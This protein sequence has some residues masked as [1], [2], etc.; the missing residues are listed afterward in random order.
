MCRLLG[1]HCLYLVCPFPCPIYNIHAPT[2]REDYLNAVIAA[3]RSEEELG[4]LIALLIERSTSKEP[5]GKWSGNNDNDDDDDGGKAEKKKRKKHHRKTQS[6]SESDSEVEEEIGPKL[7]KIERRSSSPEDEDKR[8]LRDLRER[9]EFVQR[10]QEKDKD[11]T[12]NIVENTGDRKAFEEA[13]KRLELEKEDREKILPRLRVESRRKYLGKRKDDKLKE[14][15]SDIIDDEYLFDESTLTEREK[16]ER[17]YKKKV[18]R[19][20]KDYDRVREIENIQRYSMP[21]EKKNVDDKYIEVDEKEKKFGYEQRKWEEEQMKGTSLSFGAKDKDRLYKDKEYNLVLEDEI[22]FIKSLPLEGTR[23]KKKK[24]KKEKSSDGESE[25]SSSEEESEEESFAEPKQKK[26]SIA[27]VRR[28]LPV[29]PFREAL[30]QAIEEH[31]ILIIE[32]ETGSGKTTQIPQYLHE[33]GYTAE[34]KIGC[35]QPRRVAA[36]SVAARVAQE[37]GKKL[38]NEVGYSIPI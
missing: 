3:D 31:Q 7:M 28:S 9:D 26:M 4:S 35:T 38:G 34:K 5:Y 30:L 25:S 13:A 15:E 10:L 1:A 11:K 23:K 19:L 24:K 36:M 20:A 21:D 29:Y 32:G 37:M 16:R 33:A 12:R 18:L 22:E 14:L 17:E 6:D 8:R 27:E 2:S